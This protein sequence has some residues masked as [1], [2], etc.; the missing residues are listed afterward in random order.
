MFVQFAFDH[1]FSGLN[2][3]CGALGIEQTEIVMGLGRGPFNETEGANKRPREAITADWKVQ[4]SALS[5]RALK[6]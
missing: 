1:F 4:N 3:Q 5:R 6:C 2:D